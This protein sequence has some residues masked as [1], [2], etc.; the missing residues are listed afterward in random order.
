MA[1]NRFKSKNRRI[2]GTFFVLPH[3]VMDSD[4]FKL[5]SGNALKL[6]LDMGRE[7]NG[8][9]NGDLSAAFSVMK[10]KGWVSKCTLDWSLK[11]LQYYGFIVKTRQGYLAR[12]SCLYALSWQS[13]DASYKLEL[14]A[15]SNV[16]ANTWKVP[17]D[18]F[19]RKMVAINTNY[20]RKR[21]VRNVVSNA[22]KTVTIELIPRSH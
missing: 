20:K 4:N 7:Y 5:L 6:L 11:E 10:Q 16:P 3:S 12:R 13:I 2:I 14:C 1:R 19:D 9:N 15:A 22:T 21:L 8:N 18:R 17:K